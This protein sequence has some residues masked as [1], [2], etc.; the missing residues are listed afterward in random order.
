MLPGCLGACW[1]TAGAD[2]ALCPGTITRHLK[3][4]S[5]ELPALLFSGE[6]GVRAG[7]VRGLHKQGNSALFW[8]QN[9]RPWRKMGVSSSVV[10]QLR[11]A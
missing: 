5:K 11:P 10:W 9:F 3:D 8:S 6:W 4:Q 7:R 1:E 2:R